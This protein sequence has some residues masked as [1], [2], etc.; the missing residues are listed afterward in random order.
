[1][2]ELNGFK[3]AKKEFDGHKFRVKVKITTVDNIHHLDIYTTD[4]SKESIQSV[5]IDKKSDNVTSINIIHFATKEQDDNCA[6]LITEI[7]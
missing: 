1:M 5:L 3:Y 7:L 4:P 6:A 2:L